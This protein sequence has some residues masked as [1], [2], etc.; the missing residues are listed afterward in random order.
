MDF[1]QMSCLT[2]SSCLSTVH[3]CKPWP[4]MQVTQD[5][6]SVFR[7][8]QDT[9]II[10]NFILGINLLNRQKVILCTLLHSPCW[11]STGAKLQLY[12]YCSWVKWNVFDIIS[13][14]L[15]PFPLLLT[16]SKCLLE[17]SVVLPSSRRN[18][19]IP[20]HR[21]EKWLPHAQDVWSS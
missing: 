18:D 10:R 16:L 2:P 17:S 12:M 21:R 14:L 20:A 19:Q 4:G 7:D 9:K 8:C 3:Y 11:R 13:S 15:L 6:V 5:I 1:S